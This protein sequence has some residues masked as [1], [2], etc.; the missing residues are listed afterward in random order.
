MS[1]RNAIIVYRK[2][3]MDFLRDRRTIKSMVVV[4][5]FVVPLVAIG[6]SYMNYHFISQARREIPRTMILGGEDSP[7]LMAELQQFKQIDIVPASGNYT[8][9]ILNKKLRVAVRVPSGFDALLQH[10]DQTHISIY[11]SKEE[12]TSQ[13]AADTVTK[14]FNE[15]RD[16]TSK[17]ALAMHNLP[18]NVLESIVVDEENVTPRE[19]AAGSVIARLLPYCIILLCLNGAITPAI[20]LTAGEKERGTME[21]LLCSPVSRTD[22]VIGKFLMVFTASLTT[23]ILAI[24][25]MSLY[26]MYAQKMVGAGG[27]SALPLT[28]AVRGIA[29]VFAM[30]L[31]LS[32]LFSGALLAFALFA[33][34]FREAQS[35]VAPLMLMA[36]LAAGTSFLP[37]IDLNLKTIF[38]PIVNTSLVCKEILAGKY[39]WGFIVLVFAISC[40]YASVAMSYA[41]R[42]FNNEKVLFR[43]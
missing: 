13:F 22:L 36:V 23:A 42:L 4:P 40:A 12:L 19:V 14:F 31:P 41:V 27:A 24:T 18:A 32:A 43:A 29:A 26:A 39:H 11:Y 15:L 1:F 33:R 3:L 20:D 16:K 38:I 9:E 6:M 35:Y 7:A 28:I 37:G 25:S 10:G 17:K 2:E 34:T 21:T 8:A 5:I 30:V